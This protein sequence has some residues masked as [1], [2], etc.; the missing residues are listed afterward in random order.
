MAITTDEH[1]AYRKFPGLQ[2]SDRMCQLS[3][4]PP[5]VVLA[6]EVAGS[7]V[8]VGIFHALFPGVLGRPPHPGPA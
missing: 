2:L 3:P 4:L 7:L 8:V 1:A 5:P 6:G